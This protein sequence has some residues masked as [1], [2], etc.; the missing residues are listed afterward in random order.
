MNDN[1]NHHHHHHHYDNKNNN[2]NNNRLIGRKTVVITNL[3]RSVTSYD[4]RDVLERTLRRRID[5]IRCIFDWYHPRTCRNTTVDDKDLAIVEFDRSKDM[6]D[7]LDLDRIIVNNNNNSS[8]YWNY[9]YNNNKRD[10]EKWYVFP[11]D[12]KRF[13]VEMYNIPISCDKIEH[14]KDHLW[15]EFGREFYIHSYKFDAVTV[16]VD[17]D[18][19][20][21]GRCQQNL[22]IELLSNEHASYIVDHLNNTTW[23][24]KRLIV[25]HQYPKKKKKKKKKND[26]NDKDEI[27]VSDTVVPPPAAAGT[28][29]A[30]AGAGAGT[31]T[32]GCGG[33][34]ATDANA[35]DAEEEG[36][37]GYQRTPSS[38]NSSDVVSKVTTD[39]LNQT[40]MNTMTTTTTASHTPAAVANTTI[41]T[42]DVSSSL[43]NFNGKPLEATLWDDR[44]HQ[45][46]TPVRVDDSLCNSTASHDAT[47]SQK[48]KN[49]Q[50]LASSEESVE[51]DELL[52]SHDV[53]VPATHHAQQ[54]RPIDDDFGLPRPPSP[55]QENQ[56]DRHS[57]H[58]P[59]TP[60]TES[61]SV[62]VERRICDATVS[63]QPS[64]DTADGRSDNS[65]EVY[66]IGNPEIIT[67]LH[68]A[69]EDSS[70]MAIADADASS[71]QDDN[72]DE[73][74][75]D[76]LHERSDHP[77]T[78]VVQSID[79][80]QA[81]IDRQAIEINQLR[82]RLRHLAEDPDDE[83]NVLKSKKRR[84]ET[85]IEDVQK[86]FMRV[87][88][89]LATVT[90]SHVEELAELKEVLQH[91]KRKAM[92]ET[93]KNNHAVV[94]TDSN[95]TDNRHS[96]QKCWNCGIRGCT[97]STCNKPLDQGCIEK[98]RKEY[99]DEKSRRLNPNAK[100]GR[101]DSFLDN[102]K[103]KNE[104]VKK[105]L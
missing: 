81:T 100:K 69:D 61:P 29:G 67:D 18:D 2:N 39:D 27:C 7:V 75:E 36:R 88:D 63:S 65:P 17:V 68:S 48:H 90:M 89:A 54:D 73:A 32:G 86:K 1:K 96:K 58:L 76:I 87:S 59:V 70:R 66:T 57:D 85:D 56:I 74:V 105:E 97:P 55:S 33:S 6:Q 35:G 60:E 11:W 92:T 44:P 14:L 71:G 20:G 93:T 9:Y 3:D 19:Y 46:R 102:V 80:L 101:G 52:L 4:V 16:D 51:H 45:E 41:T 30:G 47:P 40:L 79:D 31:G 50:A 72:D 5:L 77:T 53:K 78:T 34:S 28:A 22:S 25:Q 84:L 13:V 99:Y 21:R 91:E 24:G 49:G 42:N 95:N 94:V 103:V 23:K 12:K 104:V 38:N 8:N 64:R 10:F 98:N 15:M 37:G 62:D 82:D 43:L 26:D 83:I